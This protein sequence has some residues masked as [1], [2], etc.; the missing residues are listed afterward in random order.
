MNLRML[1]SAFTK[2]AL[3]HECAVATAD[4]IGVLASSGKTVEL[5]IGVYQG[6]QEISLSV[7]GFTTLDELRYYGSQII[8]QFKQECVLLTI[9][10]AVWM[11]HAGEVPDTYIGLEVNSTPFGLSNQGCGEDHTKYLN[12]LAM[13]VLPESALRKA[14]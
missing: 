13:G 11:Q 10:G 12:G 2:G 8:R 14:A 5:C 7:R 3:P 6:E 9:D 1:C 4:L